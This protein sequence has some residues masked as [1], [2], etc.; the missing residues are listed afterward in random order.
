LTE[1]TFDTGEIVINY[2]EGETDGPPLVMLH[3]SALNWQSLGEFVPKLQQHW[4]LY[5][6][7]LRGHGKSGRSQADYRV[8]DFVPDPVAL[9]ER[10]VGEPVVLLGFSMGANM[11]ELSLRKAPDLYSWV[12]WL[13]ET[14]A[15]ERTFEAIVALCKA[16]SPEMDDARAKDQATMVSS[17]DPE[18]VACLFEDRIYDGFDLEEALPSVACP[19]LLVRGERE[20]DSL[21]RDSDAAPVEALVPQDTIVQVKGVG[22]DVIWGSPGQ[23]ALGHV[24]AFLRRCKRRSI[25]AST[26]RLVTTWVV[27]DV[28]NEACSQ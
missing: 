22:H 5:A 25:L 23:V 9:V 14:L 7:D 8:V 2:A 3:R 26:R 20:P 16:L 24:I 15:T 4:H 13:R 19:E 17:V 6:C 28:R 18:S 11:R 12:V 1:Q 21:V 27:Q 10:A